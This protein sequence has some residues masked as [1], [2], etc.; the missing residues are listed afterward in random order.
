MTSIE[1]IVNK[2]IVSVSPDDSFL[3]ACRILINMGFNHLPVIHEEKVVAMITSNDALS[4]LLNPS[5]NKESKQLENLTIKDFI[6][7]LYVISMDASSSLNTLVNSLIQNDIHSMPI[8][9]NDK[10]FGV[11]TTFD[12]IKLLIKKK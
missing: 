3:E 8:T 10:P 5:F 7:Q 9:K 6:S 2:N 12:L 4:I 11:I 1:N